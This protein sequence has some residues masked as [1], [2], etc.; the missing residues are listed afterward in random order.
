MTYH[1]SDELV[2]TQSTHVVPFSAA[3][4]EDLSHSML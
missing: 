2:D 4:S 1:K 3:V